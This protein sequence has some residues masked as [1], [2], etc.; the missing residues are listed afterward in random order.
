MER[1]IERRIRKLKKQIVWYC[2]EDLTPADDKLGKEMTESELVDELDKVIGRVLETRAEY[3]KADAVL[4]S[5]APMRESRK[6]FC[7]R[8]GNKVSS[9]CSSCFVNHFLGSK[10]RN[11]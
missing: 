5:N 4:N 11:S 7:D 8:C 1:D 9:L 10:L 3:S 2:H 6:Y